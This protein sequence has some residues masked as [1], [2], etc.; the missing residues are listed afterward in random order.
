L[1]DSEGNVIHNTGSS[2]AVRSTI[3]AGAGSMVRL[4]RND[5]FNVDIA[6]GIES[7]LPHVALSQYATLDRLESVRLQFVATRFTRYCD[8]T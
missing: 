5:R 1:A 4:I 2:M 6:E 8:W 7:A 3:G